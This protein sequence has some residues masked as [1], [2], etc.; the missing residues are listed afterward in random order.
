[1]LEGASSRFSRSLRQAMTWARV[2]ERSSAMPP[3]PGEGDELLDIV[4]IGPA[5]FGVGEIGEPFEL[6]RHLGEV[7]ELGGGERAPQRRRARISDWNQVL[8]HAPPLPTHLNMIMY[9]V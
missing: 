4:L 9:H 1:M 8:F 3:E 6:G 5:G 2:M 7:A